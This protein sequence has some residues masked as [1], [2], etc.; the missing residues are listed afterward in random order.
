MGIDTQ[1]HVKAKIKDPQ[2]VEMLQRKLSLFQHSGRQHTISL[3]SSHKA[4]SCMAYS[5]IVMPVDVLV[6]HK[7]LQMLH[8]TMCHY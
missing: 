1:F 5:L 4:F 3:G 2:R 7:E 8:Q 6:A